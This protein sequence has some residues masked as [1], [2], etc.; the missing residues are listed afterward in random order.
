MII[1]E[2][3]KNIAIEAIERE[4]AA[5]LARINDEISTAAAKGL[6]STDIT[7][8]ILPPSVKEKIEESGYA[9]N[10]KRDGAYILKQ[11]ISWH[12]LM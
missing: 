12:H 4:S 2:D 7:G 6:F 8:V 11:E 9:L 5:V 1:A 3:A 10:V